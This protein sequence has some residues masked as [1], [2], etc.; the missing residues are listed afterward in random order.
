MFRLNAIRYT[1]ADSFDHAVEV[2]KK[3]MSFSHV[4][5]SAIHGWFL[6]VAFMEMFG[7]HRKT[8]YEAPRDMEK[9]CS[10]CHGKGWFGRGRPECPECN[11]SGITSYIQRERWTDS[12]NS[13][14]G[15]QNRRWR[16]Y[17]DSR[18]NDKYLSA[19]SKA[20]AKTKLHPPKWLADIRVTGASK[21]RETEIID[22]IRDRLGWRQVVYSTSCQDY[23][24]E[25]RMWASD[26]CE[27]LPGFDN[28]Q[29]LIRMALTFGCTCPITG[30]LL[31]GDLLKRDR[32]IDLPI[33]FCVP[34]CD[35][36]GD[37]LY[38]LSSVSKQG[39]SALARA[40]MS[41]HKL[42]FDTECPDDYALAEVMKSHVLK[43]IA[44]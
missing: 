33:G 25:M 22:T 37:R 11:G 40:K 39:E 14:T 43:R 2:I 6:G 34:V 36:D 28:T 30:Q 31:R 8:R 16:R 42:G 24:D 38:F 32:Y 4:P 41:W 13:M 15:I 18:L 35:R 9:T 5:D 12:G 3:T 27:K 21:A 23:H 29:C 26:G 44:A 20:M 1:W 7:Q 10:K 17:L 19:F